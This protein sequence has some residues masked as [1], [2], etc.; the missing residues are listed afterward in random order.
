M[1]VKMRECTVLLTQVVRVFR[2]FC[3]VVEHH[4]CE[5]LLDKSTEY[6]SHFSFCNLGLLLSQ[7]NFVDHH[8]WELT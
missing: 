8:F 5:V 7:R 1:R 3:S 2:E 6:N 4:F